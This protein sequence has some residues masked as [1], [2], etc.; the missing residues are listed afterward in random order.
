MA[1]VS[2]LRQL[3]FFRMSTCAYT[4]EV[5]L[6]LPLGFALARRVAV[7]VVFSVEDPFTAKKNHTNEINIPDAVLAMMSV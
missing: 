4:T 2:F 1:C 6:Q 7:L 5:E 3:I